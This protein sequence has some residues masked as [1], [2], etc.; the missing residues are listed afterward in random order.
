MKRIVAILVLLL[1]ATN[2]AANDLDTRVTNELARLD[3]SLASIDA[4]SLTPDIAP[5]VDGS[6]KLVDRVRA[7]KDPLV[8]IYRLRD[9]FINVEALR[10]VL[11]HKSASKDLAQVEALA[12]ASRDAIERP[13]APMAGPALQLALRQETHNHAQ[14]VHRAAVPYAKVDAPSSGVYYLGEAE[15]NRKYREFVESLP[16]EKKNEPR[17]SRAALE[18]ALRRLDTAALAAFERDP[19]GRS[20]IGMS[21]RLKEARELFD[22]GSFEGAALM[23]VEAQL[24]ISRK[25]AAAK[26]ATVPLASA[27]HADSLSAMLQNIAREDATNDTAKIVTADMLPLYGSLYANVVAEKKPPRSVTVTLV[28]WP[29]T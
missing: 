12:R 28:R 29:Y 27:P 20:A 5:L 16:F 10:Y 2:L 15:G 11:D 19:G 8:R 21:A 4:A 14:V 22:R 26:V 23:L 13:L 17:P 25:N 6:R 18:A 9:A 24:D 1:S 7:T 3:A